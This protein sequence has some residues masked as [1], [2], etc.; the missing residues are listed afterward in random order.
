[1]TGLRGVRCA[2]CGAAFVAAIDNHGEAYLGCARCTLGP[3]AAG[4]TAASLAGPSLAQLIAAQRRVEQIWRD[5]SF[6]HPFTNEHL[7]TIAYALG[8]LSTERLTAGER[9]DA[10]EAGL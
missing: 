10:G 6:V 1:M 7:A 9:L 4:R 5:D 8:V 3:P 2:G